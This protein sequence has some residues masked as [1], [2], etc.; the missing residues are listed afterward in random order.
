MSERTLA[1]QQDECLYMIRHFVVMGQA[2][3]ATLIADASR[4][5]VAVI[6][7][8]P[9]KFDVNIAPEF[10][11]AWM[12]MIRDEQVAT[13]EDDADRATG[14]IGLPPDTVQ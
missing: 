12:Q 3:P 6:T 10:D 2:F 7:G 14:V 8:G 1:E 11:A 9:T 5:G 13:F 4:L